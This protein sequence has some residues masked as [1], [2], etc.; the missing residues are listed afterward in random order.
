MTIIHCFHLANHT[1]WSKWFLIN[2]SPL[3]YNPSFTFMCRVGKKKLNLDMKI[4]LASS[5][6]QHFKKCNHWKWFVITKCNIQSLWTPPLP[7]NV[8]I[9]IIF[10]YLI[11]WLIHGPIMMVDQWIVVN[12][13]CK[14]LP[15][16]FEDNRH[17]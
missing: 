10:L 8:I 4:M 17:M 3:I 9:D 15:P 11:I 7:I 12:D 2:S 6:I 16:I 1:G 14:L 13:F 5:Q